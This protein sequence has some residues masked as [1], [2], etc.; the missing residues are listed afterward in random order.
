MATPFS[1]RVTPLTHKGQWD[2]ARIP[3][4]QGECQVKPS[5]R[6]TSAVCHRVHKVQEGKG[7]QAFPHSRSPCC[8]PEAATPCSLVGAWESIL[9]NDHFI[10]ANRHLGLLPK[11][12]HRME[13]Q[14]NR[15][16]GI[17]PARPVFL[18]GAHCP[19][20]CLTWAIAVG[21]AYEGSGNNVFRSC[22]VPRVIGPVR[23][24]MMRPGRY[25]DRLYQ[26]T[27]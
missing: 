2:T 11:R 12:L 18:H 7:E 27:R 4:S 9:M 3:V 25:G 23:Y 19:V 24:C 1:S 8:R 16:P 10:Y 6:V 20:S 26:Y 21:P 17:S 13:F 15:V 14:Y 5:R 22:N